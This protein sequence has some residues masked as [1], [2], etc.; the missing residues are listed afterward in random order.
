MVL[1]RLFLGWEI[2]KVAQRKRQRVRVRV[3][4]ERVEKERVEK[5]R[6][7]E[8]ATSAG[9]AKISSHKVGGTYAGLPFPGG[10]GTTFTGSHIHGGQGQQPHAG[11]RTDFVPGS[12]GSLAGGFI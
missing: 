3:E 10:V 9:S 11:F 8:R 12:C 5:E 1:E 4:K 7:R 2:G 6:E